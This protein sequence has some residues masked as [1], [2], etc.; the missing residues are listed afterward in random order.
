M[1]IPTCLL[2]LVLVLVFLEWMDPGP[3]EF[4]SISGTS[5]GGGTLWGLLS[6]LTDVSSFDGWKY[7]QME[8]TKT[9]IY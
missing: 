1:Y 7:H 4:S 8:I 2:T 5:L 6:L 9:W 3:N